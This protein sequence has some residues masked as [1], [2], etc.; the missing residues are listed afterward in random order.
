MFRIYAG[1]EEGEWGIDGV[2]VTL[3]KRGV[4]FYN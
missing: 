4:L 2:K 3:V 1:G